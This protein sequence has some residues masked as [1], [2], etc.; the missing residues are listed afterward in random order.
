MSIDEEQVLTSAAQ[1]GKLEAVKCCMQLRINDTIPDSTA[2][3]IAATPGISMAVMQYIVTKN[4]QTLEMI[5]AAARGGNQNVIDLLLVYHDGPPDDAAYEIMKNAALAGREGLVWY[6][7]SMLATTASRQEGLRLA[8]MM[9]QRAG[10]E[11]L[12]DEV[13]IKPAF[14]NT[15]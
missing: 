14:L 3:E 15:M 10:R 1:S 12:R 11:D 5:G 7:L 6:G 13:G 9:A 2:C 8:K 4:K